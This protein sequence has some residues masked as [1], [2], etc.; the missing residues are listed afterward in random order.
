MEVLKQL[1]GFSSK[2]GYKELLR[3]AVSEDIQAPL[4]TTY[5]LVS[6]H[7][8]GACLQ[9]QL[10]GLCRLLHTPPYLTAANLGSPFDL[11]PWS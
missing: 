5:P 1:S 8:P 7:T 3:L 11:N 4:S 9:Q 2:R 10:E 6:A